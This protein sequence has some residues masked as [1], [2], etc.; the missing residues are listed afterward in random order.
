MQFF[1]GCEQCE[2]VMKGVNQS[3]SAKYAC[4]NLCIVWRGQSGAAILCCV[5]V[6]HADKGHAS[7]VSAR[8]I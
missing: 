5:N 8:S 7:H 2:T 1:S 3:M 6:S 4:A